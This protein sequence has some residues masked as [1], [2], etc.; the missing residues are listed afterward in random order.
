MHFNYYNFF[1]Y[2]DN[3]NL[4]NITKFNK[5]VNIIFRNYKKRFKNQDLAKLVHFCKKNKR[6]IYLANDIKRAKILNFDGVYIPSF[7]KLS[8]NYDKGIRDNFTILGSAHNMREVKIKKDQKI[9]IIFLSPLFK[10]NKNRDN[11]G[12]IKFNLLKQNFNN[13]FIAL[14]GI[15]NQNKCMLKLL[16]VNGFAAISYFNGKN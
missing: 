12:I 3:T 5:K 15:N 7:N 16:N 8:I 2:I 1:T 4:E 10:N 6:K 14:G 11:L 9:D 13:K